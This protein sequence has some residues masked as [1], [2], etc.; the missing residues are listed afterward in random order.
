[1]DTTILRC[2][3]CGSQL[4]FNALTQ[5]WVCDSC[6]NTYN[7][8]DVAQITTDSNLDTKTHGQDI[9]NQP[10]LNLFRCQSCGAEMVSDEN[11][12]ATFC[13]Y[14][15]NPGIMK[16]RLEGKYRPDKIIP[17]KKTKEDAI[18]AYNKCRLGKPFAPPEFGKPEN[19]EKI[20][21]IYIPFWLYDGLSR[22][23]VS[24][25]S[26]EYT[27]WSKGDY[28]Y[29]RTDTYHVERLANMGFKN[30]P[31]DASVKFDDATMDSI[32]PYDFNELQKF[33]YSYLSGF[34]AEKFDVTAADDQSRAQSRMENSIMASIRNTIKGS[35]SSAEENK[36]TV[37][38][39]VQYAL[40]PVWMLNTIIDG[41]TYTFAMNGQTGRLVGNIP[42]SAKQILKFFL[43][44]AAI[45]MAVLSLLAYWMF[46]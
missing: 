30:V 27:S 18:E 9:D 43:I 25:T 7:E 11:T 37:F 23:Y 21:G 2:P 15:G 45:A 44:R 24:G 8:K 31:A 42:T 6:G 20:S 32:E 41:K 16:S 19:I 4:Q 35:F 3:A 39:K 40:L 10:A 46:M 28:R 36:T 34:L 1:M 14:C 17:F 33:N 29:T 5:N 13:V 12:T 38:D 22:A 26:T